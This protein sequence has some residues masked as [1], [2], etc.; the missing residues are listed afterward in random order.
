MNPT[1]SLSL[2]LPLALIAL[3]GCGKSANVAGPLAHDP[4]ATQP[5]DQVLAMSALSA[6]SQVVED[7]LADSPDP[8]SLGGS[9]DA[10]SAIQPLTFWRTIRNVTRTFE[11]TFSDP[12]TTG[13]PTTAVV[14]IHKL[15]AGRFNILAGAPGTDGLPPDSAETVVHKPL[16][17]HWVRRVLLK[18]VRLAGDEVE[19]GET[20]EAIW[21]IAASSGVRVTSKDAT[22]QILSLRVQAM[23]LDTTLTDPLA[24]QRMRRILRFAPETMVTLTVTTGR[25]N[26]VVVLQ[27]AGLRFRFHNNGDDT[28][29]GTWRTGLFAAGV[30]H[31]GINALS[32]GTLFDDQA[33]YD[34]V[35]WIFPY[36]IEPESLSEFM[37]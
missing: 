14:T 18:R 9:T 25:N 30:H 26:D 24:F 29:T 4:G 1:R 12:D 5:N 17:D 22:T 15:L 31:F 11:F 20:G 33:A 28:Y 2:I 10:M 13:R 16:E 3:S 32:N 23:G 6:E 36:A 34:S 8:T 27:H 19:A 37:P 35:E 7:G 21:R